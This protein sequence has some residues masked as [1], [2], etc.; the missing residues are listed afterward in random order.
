MSLLTVGGRSVDVVHVASQL[1]AQFDVLWIPESV[2]QIWLEWLVGK[3]VQVL[4]PELISLLTDASDGLTEEEIA[5][6]TEELTTLAN[7]IIDIPVL[8]ESIEASLIRPVV[9]QLLSY[10]KTGQALTLTAGA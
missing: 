2:E 7:G 1:N 4:P 8:A 5:A 9:K 10:A 6:H 3:I